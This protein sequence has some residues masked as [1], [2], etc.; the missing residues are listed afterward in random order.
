MR[1]RGLMGGIE[2]Y[3][4]GYVK[5]GLIFYLD[6]IDKGSTDG[7]WTDLIKGLKFNNVNVEDKP[8][9]WYFNKS[10]YFENTQAH[11]IVS[12]YNYT[13]EVIFTPYERAN[14]FVFHILP[15][16]AGVPVFHLGTSNMITWLQYYYEYP[17]NI[18]AN[19]LYMCGFNSNKGVINNSP[20]SIGSHSDYWSGQ[21]GDSYRF[22]IGCRKNN[23]SYK[24]YFKGMIYSI[25]IY[26]R[27]LSQDEILSNQ[28]NDIT[29][30]NLNIT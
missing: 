28:D 20:V 2:G 29:R 1:R 16:G 4:N 13:V 26:D 12:N 30:Y 6:G 23:N 10:A 7:T 9:G 8:V 27:K 21:A 14:C 3:I 17:L 22:I 24:E 15:N 5:K 11:N 25:R 19:T 18:V